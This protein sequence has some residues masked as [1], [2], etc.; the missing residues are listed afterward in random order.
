[1]P[2]YITL[3]RI[4]QGYEPP[5]FVSGRIFP[6]IKVPGTPLRLK[7]FGK[8][9][10]KRYQSRRAELA[11]SN[12]VG[13]VGPEYLDVTIEPRDNV[14]QFDK[15]HTDTPITN[16]LKIRLAKLAKQGVMMDVEIEN[17][18]RL[19]DVNNYPT[20]NKITLSGT[21]Q[22]SDFTN[23]EP[24]QVVDDAKITMS[25]KIGKEP[26]L[27]TLPKD[28]FDKI[29]WHPQLM[30]KS[31]TGEDTAATI[32]RLQER[33]GIEEIVIAASLKLNETTNEFEWIWTK[34]IF[35]GYVNPN[36]KPSVEEISFGYR[37]RIEGYPKV[38]DGPDDKIDR[39]KIEAK[40]YNDRFE[41]AILGAEAG[42]LIKA[43]IA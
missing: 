6:E 37:L 40:R 21:D 2:E 17:A 15:E 38:D 10:F 8:D 4:V 9:M 41:D 31:V 1:M 26:N 33:F 39:T 7:K 18:E 29:K 22:F 35:L 20:G 13:M 12:I 23:S 24:I 11:S 16:D 42:Y 43:A 36:P 14:R 3:K 32:E 34:D 28:V 30:V 25:K 27:M 19:F 5:E